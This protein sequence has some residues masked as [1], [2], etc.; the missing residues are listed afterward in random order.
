MLFFSL[1]AAVVIAPAQDSNSGFEGRP[2]ARIEFSPP[3]Q[4]LPA[5]EMQSL[6]TFE[7]GSPLKLTDVRAAIQKLYQTGRFSNVSI[8]GI[9][10][11]S[12]VDRPDHDRA[13]L[14]RKLA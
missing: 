10:E 9:T 3:E 12:G 14:F 11:G 6:L 2:I 13:E 4:P 8:E 5:D 1:L 7:R